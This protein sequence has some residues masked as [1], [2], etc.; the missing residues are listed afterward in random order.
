[1]FGRFSSFASTTTACVLL[2]SLWAGFATDALASKVTLAWDPNPESDIAGYRVHWGVG[3]GQY[4]YSQ[5]VGTETIATIENLDR[6]VTFY[7]AVTAYN[8][9]QLESEFS[10]EV[11][12]A[13]P[14]TDWVAND[15][16][17]VAQQGQSLVV[18]SP[19]ILANDSIYSSITPSILVVS[20]PAHGVLVINHD[21]SF[22]YTPNGGYRGVDQFLYVLTDGT[23]A[24]YA[25]VVQISVNASSPLPAGT[26]PSLL[27]SLDEH[28]ASVLHVRF[29][30]EVGKA[31]SL[32]ASPNLNTWESIWAEPIL[33]SG[34]IDVP[35][36]KTQAPDN[37]FYRLAISDQ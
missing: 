4:S 5:D 14:L 6:G 34:W 33:H 8:T 10:D 35:T 28:N 30:V 16:L 12:F 17:Y 36:L 3:S 27:L 22:Q 31:Y 37:R 13:V 7:F 2:A 23:T 1:M 15:D 18:S 32:Q 29:P 26:S 11:S 9:A 21:G 25:A 20:A 19:G 24:D